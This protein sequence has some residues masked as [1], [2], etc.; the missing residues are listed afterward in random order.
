MCV[1]VCVCI[2]VRARVRACVSVSRAYVCVSVTFLLWPMTSGHDV[3][4][5]TN[6]HTQKTPDWTGGMCIWETRVYTA[7]ILLLSNNASNC[8]ICLNPPPS[9]CD[10]DHHKHALARMAADR[11]A[12]RIFCMHS[13]NMPATSPPLI[14]CMPMT[15]MPAGGQIIR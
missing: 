4:T 2:C 6:T 12:R 5:W 7:Y 10:A 8:Y 14:M 11:N 15:R 9:G 13:I 1:C 3:H